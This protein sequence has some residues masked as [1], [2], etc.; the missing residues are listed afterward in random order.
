[1]LDAVGRAPRPV[2]LVVGVAAA[3]RRRSSI[4]AV[5]QFRPMVARRR[6]RR[7]LPVARVELLPRI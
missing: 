2:G 1:M 6:R 5:D 3:V 4:E 7:R